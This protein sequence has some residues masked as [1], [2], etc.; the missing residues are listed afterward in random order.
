[1]PYSRI[2][3]KGIRLYEATSELDE[4]HGSMVVLAA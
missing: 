3:L 2:G 4:A 1:M